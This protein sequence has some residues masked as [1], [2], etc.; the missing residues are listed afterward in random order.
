MKYVLILG[1]GMADYPVAEL[2]SKTPLE[3]A[4]KPN[5]DNLARKS[6]L[7]LVHTVPEGMSPGSD[8]A[9]L[10]VLGYNP[11]EYYTGR[12]PL[13]AL[14]MGI[15]LTDTDIAVRA[16]LVTLSDESEYSDKTM[17]DYSAGEISTDEAREL[18]EFI[19]SK[20]GNEIISFT[21]GVSYRHCLVIHNTV[22][23]TKLVPPHDITNKPIATS[24]PMGEN[25]NLMLDIMKKS[26]ELLRSHPI[27]ISRTKKGLNPANSLW[28]WGEGTRPQLTDFEEKFGLKGSI[29]S[30]VDLL[31][32]I[33]KGAN[34]KSVDVIGATGTIHTN[35]SGKAQACLEEL[36]RGQD[37]VYLHI[38]AP[39]ECGH[40]GD[41]YGKVKAIELID[42]KIV[43]PII[44][45]L[46][47]MGEDYSILIMPDHPTPLI[48]RT[49]SSDSVP[50]LLYRS[51]AKNIG[52]TT[53][54]EKTATDSG[55][56]IELGHEL[57]KRFVRK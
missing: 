18:I 25:G 42:S 37:F 32:G 9:N 33:A 51:N 41:I 26:Y 11:L 1:D 56:I 14:S 8:T 20:L 23:G 38:E 45:G 39:D 13:E 29:I 54:T 22:T 49:H 55:I 28:L 34:M 16:N 47:I 30:A 27:N 35:F 17:L 46:N 43:E 5:I 12:S 6:E 50:Y 10:S 7:G 40:Q 44:K 31:K 21:S 15:D 3:V 19:Q 24:L 53:Y 2:D 48:T 4:N 57:M 52:A 36:K